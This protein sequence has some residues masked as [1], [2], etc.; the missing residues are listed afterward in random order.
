MCMFLVGRNANGEVPEKVLR[1][2]CGIVAENKALTAE[3]DRLWL[4]AEE[5]VTEPTKL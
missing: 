2:N 4:E 1:P 3:I 5:N